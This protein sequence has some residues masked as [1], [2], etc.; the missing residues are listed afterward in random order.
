METLYPEMNT[1]NQKLGFNKRNLKGA[2]EELKRLAY[3][4]LV[5]SSMEYECTVW[6]PSL[7]KDSESLERIQRW[8][9]QWITRKC[10]HT[11]SVSALLHQLYLESLEERRRISRLTFLNKVLHEHVAVS[12]DHLNLILAERPVHGTDEIETEDP[13]LFHDPIP[14]I[15][16]S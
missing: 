14:E 3:V 11:S 2:P 9:A 5:R 8:T 10:D 15:L 1:T 16:C 6:D 4:T 12:P 7:S 13:S